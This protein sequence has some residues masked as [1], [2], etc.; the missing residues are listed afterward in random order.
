[1]RERPVIQ[2]AHR[3]ERCIRNV[4]SCEAC[5]YRFERT[6]YFSAAKIQ[7]DLRV[8]EIERAACTHRSA[9]AAWRPSASVVRCCRAWPRFEC[10]NAGASRRF[11]YDFC[12]GRIFAAAKNMQAIKKP[13]TM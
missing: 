9:E 4:W 11:D 1:M 5:G 7:S 6:V 3:S 12:R 8:E 2:C 10:P 13:M